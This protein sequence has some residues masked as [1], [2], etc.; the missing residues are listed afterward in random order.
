MR[1]AKNER[2][3]LKRLRSMIVAGTALLAACAPQNDAVGVTPLGADA[4]VEQRVV[5]SG[6][7]TSLA[8]AEP[9]EA[10]GKMDGD[11]SFHASSWRCCRWR[12]RRL[13]SRCC[14]AP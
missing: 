6:L 4:T 3:T 1:E 11:R 7:S 2:M 9:F 10:F 13:S 5:E 14:W 12:M 8:P